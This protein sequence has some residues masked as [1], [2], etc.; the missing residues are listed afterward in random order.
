MF[1]FGV[2][3]LILPQL[4]YT[5]CRRKREVPFSVYY[6]FRWAPH[7]SSVFW[8]IQGFASEGKRVEHLT[9]ALRKQEVTYQWKEGIITRFY[10]RRQNINYI[11]AF[12]KRTYV[13]IDFKNIH[14]IYCF[15]PPSPPPTP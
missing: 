2:L 11:T 9:E 13:V 12:N 3:L 5:Q 1:A 4:G 10:L 6:T 8:R 7:S 14:P 15:C